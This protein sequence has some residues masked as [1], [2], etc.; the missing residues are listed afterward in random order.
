MKA[1]GTAAA[2]L[3]ALCVWIKWEFNQ[4]FAV[5]FFV[6]GACACWHPCS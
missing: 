6:T 1:L 3:G 4:S 5:D 2:L